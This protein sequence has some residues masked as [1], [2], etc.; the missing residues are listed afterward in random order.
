MSI[1]IHPNTGIGSEERPFARDAYT[2]RK[3][4]GCLLCLDQDLKTEGV[5]EA[6]SGREF[7]SEIR[8]AESR[9]PLATPITR[10]LRDDHDS[11][12]SQERRSALGCDGGSTE[13]PSSH[14]FKLSAKPRIT[15][16]ILSSP[17]HNLNLP[18]A[19]LGTKLSFKKVGTTT[20]AVEQDD[21]AP[22]PA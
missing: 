7:E 15:A 3:T 1:Q 16:H 12:H 11:T 21:P 19:V 8:Q 9:P 5:I 22:R 20:I 14:E 18:V 2:P 17:V 13:G 10:G 6:V 4:A